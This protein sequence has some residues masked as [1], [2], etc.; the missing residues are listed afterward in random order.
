MEGV[1]S[2]GRFQEGRS[3]LWYGC[4]EEI[5][6]CEGNDIVGRLE[7]EFGVF[8]SPLE[9]CCVAEG[10]LLEKGGLIFEKMEVFA[11]LVH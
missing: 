4:R 7:G 9:K 3:P 1:F 8:C 11:R 2:K 6:A 5:G 10:A